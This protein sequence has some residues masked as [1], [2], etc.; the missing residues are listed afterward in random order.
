MTTKDKATPNGQPDKNKSV[1][2]NKDSFIVSQVQTIFLYRQNNIAT[3]SMVS[4]ATGI[5]KKNITR[6]K[7][8]LEMAGRLWELKKS[9]CVHTGFRARYCTTNP[10]LAK[11]GPSK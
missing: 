8:Y 10:D 3:A 6:Y 9:I 5:L 11:G 4:A 1:K 7:R 2:R